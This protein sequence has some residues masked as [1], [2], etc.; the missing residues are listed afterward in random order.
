MRGSIRRPK[1][2]VAGVAVAVAGLVVTVAAG[3]A[4]AQPANKKTNVSANTSA[5]SIADIGAGSAPLTDAQLAAMTPDQQARVLDPLRA[6]AEALGTAGRGGIADIYGNVLIDANDGLV[7]LYLTDTK[8]APRAIAA[9]RA[10]N[11]KVDASR[12]RVLSAAATHNALDAASQRI[13]AMADA[14]RL[15]FPIGMVGP[16]PDASGVEVDVAD[17]AALSA[18]TQAPAAPAPAAVGTLTAKLGVP[19]TFRPGQA[20]AP[21]AWDATKWHDSAPFI[22]GDAIT[23]SGSGHGCTAGLPAVRLSDNHPVMVTA[24]HCFGVG[25]AVYTRAGTPGSYSNGLKGNYVGTV[26]DRDTAWDAEIIDGA[27]NNAD[28]SDTTGWKPMTSSA[29]SYNGDYVCHDGQRSYFM[30]HPTPCNIKVTNQ[31]KYCGPTT[32]CPGLP[33]TA[34]GVWGE[35]VN[36]GWGSA[37]GDSGATI[38][39]V[40]SGDVRQARGILSDGDPADG[41]PGVFWT[42]ATDILNHWHLTLNSRT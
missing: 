32:G 38:F 19:L 30:G 33:Y 31:D 2:L 20:L 15:P 42:E 28:E 9:A 23:G 37:G 5:N 34:R 11:P 18:A 29:Y 10:V 36:G 6:V 16:A 21:K 17:P 4:T 3:P 25:A 35:T 40:E 39:A 27:D 22:G 24:A 26:T 1:H 7:K 12:I 41:A 13:V 14:H 8:Q